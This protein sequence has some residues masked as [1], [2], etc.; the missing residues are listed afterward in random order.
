MPRDTI[1]SRCDE[2]LSLLGLEDEE[3]KLTLEYSTA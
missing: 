2:L 3:T 1:R